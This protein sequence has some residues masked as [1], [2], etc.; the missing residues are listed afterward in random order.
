MRTNIMIDDELMTDVLKL[1]EIKSK[2][3]AVEQGLQTLRAK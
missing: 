1:T 2:R 3:E